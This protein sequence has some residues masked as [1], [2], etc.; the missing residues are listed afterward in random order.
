MRKLSAA[1]AVLA[2]LLSGCEA[3]S[4]IESADNVSTD[5]LTEAAYASITE[6]NGTT[7]TETE[8]ETTPEETVTESE[9]TAVSEG[10]EEETAEE[11]VS[12]TEESREESIGD[13]KEV[14]INDVTYTYYK[15]LEPEL[16][17]K[18]R[19]IG[20]VAKCTAA[21]PSE[22]YESSFAPVG[23]NIYSYGNGSIALLF[24]DDSAC[25]CADEIPSEETET[26]AEEAPREY[27]SGLFI[28]LSDLPDLT[29]Y[30]EYAENLTEE[31]IL[32]LYTITV[33]EADNISEGYAV[34]A[35]YADGRIIM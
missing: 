25:I 5:I 3:S 17:D 2:M 21:A 4:A 18:S 24:A 14:R 29:G 31:S 16:I 8:T 23:T 1:A 19:L 30:E 13:I 22:N 27:A 34:M 6:D 11:T 10:Y 20:I 12:E 26:T 15:E 28:T 9:T 33:P 32:M 35:L 7:V